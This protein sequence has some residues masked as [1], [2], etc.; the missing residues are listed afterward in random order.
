MEYDSKKTFILSWYL[1]FT[2]QMQK[3]ILRQWAMKLSVKTHFYVF[4]A[5]HHPSTSITQIKT[6][7]WT[8]NSLVFLHKIDVLV[9]NWQK[10]TKWIRTFSF[11]L[12]S[13][14]HNVYIFIGYPSKLMIQLSY[15]CLNKISKSQGHLL[16][17]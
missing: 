16:T 7:C 3:Y 17:L 5:F 12:I 4:L 6:Y 8:F 10:Y 1:S 14:S 13:F 11:T 2:W 15:R 9:K